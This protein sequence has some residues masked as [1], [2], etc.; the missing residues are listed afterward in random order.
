MVCFGGY[1]YQSFKTRFYGEAQTIARGRV[2][3]II[4]NTLTRIDTMSPEDFRKRISGIYSPELNNRFIRITKGEEVIYL[5]GKPRDGFF[6]PKDIAPPKDV[7]E[8][9][10]QRIELPRAQTG[11]MLVTIP[12]TISDVHYNVQLG[13][14]TDQMDAAIS[15]LLDTLLLTFP[16]AGFVTALGGYAL[17]RRALVPVEDIRATA[18]SITFGNLS[19]RLPVTASG[20]ALEHLSVTL[21]QMLERLEESYQRASRFSADASHELRTPLTIIRAELESLVHESSKNDAMRERIGS[22]LEEVERL[23]RITESLF[24]IS[25]LDAGEAKITNA[26]CDL[27]EIVTS[28]AEQMALLAEEKNIALNVDAKTS[29]WV[30]GDASRLKQVA[31]N[32]LDNAIKYTPSGGKISLS[33]GGTPHKAIL[34]VKDTGIGVSEDALPHVFDRFYR[35]DTA[36]SREQGGAGLGLSIVRSI[37]QAHGGSVDMQSTENVGTVVTVE[38]PLAAK[39][40]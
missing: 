18:E 37:C 24:T 21:N 20:D 6:N 33:L 35:A 32:L 30:A 26:R 8:S 2:Q 4:D 11:L 27:G 10:F 5:S 15:E 16:V 19:N 23:S 17:V 31:V 3:Q 28:T 13:L 39:P 34:Y 14:V 36:R 40:N 12:A 1:I 22:V 7:F 25:R 29:I 9:A 38:L